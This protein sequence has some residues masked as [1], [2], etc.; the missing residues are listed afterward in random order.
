MY[1]KDKLKVSCLSMMSFSGFLALFLMNNQ[2]NLFF[3][4]TP[5]I[6]SYG[7]YFLMPFGLGSASIALIKNLPCND[8]EI[9]KGNDIV[10]VEGNLIPAYMGMF[11]I[12]L[13]LNMDGD[14]LHSVLIMFFLLILW[15]NIGSVSYFN[16]F[17]TILGYRFYAIRTQSNK[18]ITVITNKKDFKECHELN[19]LSRINNYT[20]YWSGNE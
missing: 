12:A 2:V 14:I 3:L 4:N 5:L 7:M 16:P 6:Y 19:Q 18:T 1:L 15:L 17:L 20:F 11:V 13:S 10:P 9:V 8:N